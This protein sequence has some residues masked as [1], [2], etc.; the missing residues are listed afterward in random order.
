MLKKKKTI[1]STDKTAKRIYASCRRD[2]DLPCWLLQ[3]FENAVTSNGKQFIRDQNRVLED[4]V[5]SASASSHSE[6]MWKT[7]RIR[8]NRSGRDREKL[9]SPCSL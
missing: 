3:A 9:S 4:C 5:F 2:N 7:F 8:E 1:I 6:T